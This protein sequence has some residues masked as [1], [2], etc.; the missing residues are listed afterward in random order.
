MKIENQKSN[1]KIK[2]SDLKISSNFETHPPRWEK[3]QK[4]YE[5]YVSTGEL[6]KP[7]LITDNVLID[8]YAVY[9]VARMFGVEYVEVE[10]V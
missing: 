7:I 4:C 8:N 1:I 2:L 3:V 10:E 5:H 6:G 9:L